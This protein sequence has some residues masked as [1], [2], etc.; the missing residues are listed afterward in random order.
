MNHRKKD[1]WTIFNQIF[2]VLPSVLIAIV[3]WFVMSG[4]EREKVR[5]EYVRIATTILQ[6]EANEIDSQ[7]GMREWAVAVLNRSAPVRLSED[8]AKALMEGT[9]RL[10]RSGYL[11]DEGND[12]G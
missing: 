4:S 3:V 11:D 8:Q 12:W 9:A 7:R 2:V 10:P 6:R 5:L 1:Y